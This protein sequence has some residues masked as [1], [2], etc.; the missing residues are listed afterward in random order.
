M[1]GDKRGMLQSLAAVPRLFPAC[2][3]LDLRRC[4]ASDAVVRAVAQAR[5]Q[6]TTVRLKV[7]V[8]V[9][10]NKRKQVGSALALQALVSRVVICVQ[11]TAARA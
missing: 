11:L 8:T 4:K 5:P 10:V 9:S 7:G 3:E 6:V 1:G 2:T